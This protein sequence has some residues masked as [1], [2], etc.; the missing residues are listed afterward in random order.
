MRPIPLLAAA[1]LVASCVTSGSA[2]STLGASIGAYLAEL[3]KDDSFSGVVLVAKDFVPFATKATG[4][5]D[6]ARGARNATITPFNIASVTKLFT[7]VAI[8][9]LVDQGKI[10]LDDP[11]TKYLPT[12]PK[13]VGD[14]ITIAMLLGHTAGTGDYLN[15][16]GYA[17]VRDSF[18]SV[19]D[20][21]GAVNT[22]VAPG[23]VPG[24]TVTYSNT[25]YLLLGAVIEKATGRDYY[26]Y[27]D[28]EVFA[29]AGVASGFLHNTEEDRTYR[30]FAL[31]YTS[32]GSKNWG[33]LPVRG[34]PAGDAYASAPDLVSF[35]K[36]LASGALVKP[37]T[38]KRLVIIP[39]PSGQT[40]PGLAWGVFA[41][42]DVGAS[43]VF[44]MTPSG[45]TVIVLANVGE[46]AQ[47]VADRI[48]KLIG[49]GS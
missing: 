31:G 4:Y 47:P 32:D 38:L 21:L 25:G 20:L 49:S 11:L 33:T 8:G 29:K 36:A 34:T 35:H 39:P 41:G 24:K 15:D 43:A 12:Y 5:A 44:G 37:E 28:N 3:E 16:P 27:L 18:E 22:E 19:S 10:A 30:G 7:A 6:R 17:G 26:D 14:Q 9:Q 45:Y 40:S 1:M 46:V 23:T 2:R 42:D 48:L 13:P